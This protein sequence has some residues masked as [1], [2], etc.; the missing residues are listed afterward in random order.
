MQMD[1]AKVLLVDD[2][3]DILDIL[4]FN[5]N[6]AGYQVLSSNN[7]SDAVL[8]ADVFQPDCI[9]LD[10]MMPIMNG[11]DT[12]K[13][14][15]ANPKLKEVPILFLTAMVDD[16][17]QIK[18]LELGAD[19]YITKPIQPKLF[20][21][22]VNAT[23][24]RFLQEEEKLIFQNLEIDKKR[25]LI[26]LKGNAIELAKKEFE[27]FYLLA[28]QPGKVFLR[29]EILDKIWGS[30]IIVGNRTIDVHVR[31]IRKKL[32]EDYIQTIKGIGYKF[33]DNAN[34]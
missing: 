23:L 25:H 26:F 1:K 7:G 27:L 34:S 18:G 21:S 2:E 17:S 15:R 19:D 31:K 33:I 28:S 24:R 14:L 13:M 10:V 4:S 29:Q 6:K 12:C 16:E 32:D 9:V 20:V 11:F 22:K 8:K 30:D 3:Q 5:L